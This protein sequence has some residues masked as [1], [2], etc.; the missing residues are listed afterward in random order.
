MT[1]RLRVARSGTHGGWGRVAHQQRL[2]RWCPCA[3]PSGHELL[4]LAPVSPAAPV[5]C[6]FVAGGTWLRGTD[7]VSSDGCRDPNFPFAAAYIALRSAKVLASNF[8]CTAM[9]SLY[10]LSGFFILSFLYARK[11]FFCM[12]TNFCVLILMCSA[13]RWNCSRSRCVACSNIFASISCCCFNIAISSVCCCT[14]PSMSRT[15]SSLSFM[16]SS[17]MCS[18]RAALSCFRASLLKLRTDFLLCT[19]TTHASS[20]AQRTSA[21]H[22]ASACTA[23]HEQLPQCTATEGIDSAPRKGLALRS[24]WST[25]TQAPTRLLCTKTCQRLPIRAGPSVCCNVLQTLPQTETGTRRRNGRFVGTSGESW[26]SRRCR[27]SAA[28]VA[29][30]RR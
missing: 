19:R 26:L 10:F 27:L 28:V 3:C 2:F 13:S 22:V 7:S 5:A 12:L 25:Y 14:V 23:V 18:S 6:P 29:R 15:W 11:L 21:R 16:V 17:L 9:P 4:L 30:T 1:C 8:D 20:C 24:T